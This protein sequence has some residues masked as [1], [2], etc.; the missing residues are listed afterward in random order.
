V[1]ALAALQPMSGNGRSDQRRRS[2]G[3]DNSEE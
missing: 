2:G 3:T 1:G